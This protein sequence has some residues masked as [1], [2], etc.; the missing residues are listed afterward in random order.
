MVEPSCPVRSPQLLSRLGVLILILI[1]LAG[2]LAAQGLPMK[3]LLETEH[4]DPSRA[5]T[6]PRT[7]HNHSGR[8]S[9][10]AT[11]LDMRDDQVRLVRV[12][13]GKTIELPLAA[14]S[15]EDQLFCRQLSS[16][17]SPPTIDTEES[18]VVPSWERLFQVQLDAIDASIS[19]L[20]QELLRITKAD[21]TTLVLEQDFSH[22]WLDFLQSVRGKPVRVHYTLV[23]VQEGKA[24]SNGRSEIKLQ[25]ADPTFPNDGYSPE[26]TVAQSARDARALQAGAIIQLD[27]QVGSR[28]RRTFDSMS[29]VRRLPNSPSYG[30]SLTLGTTGR[31]SKSAANYL[32]WRQLPD[33]DD[34]PGIYWAV[35]LVY[36]VDSLRV[37]SGK[38][39]D[40]YHAFLARRQGTATDRGGSTSALDGDIDSGDSP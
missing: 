17:S 33:E 39:L 27:G 4:E 15:D 14:L 25:L 36:Y 1:A 3:S 35:T 28:S 20:D 19:T 30:T 8:F 10:E 13:N 22:A 12:D 31:L 9:V 2:P 34:R 5:E 26:I 29:F 38:S 11:F 7:W 32:G 23:D 6:Q 24:L 18:N 21:D 16:P 37:L 40:D